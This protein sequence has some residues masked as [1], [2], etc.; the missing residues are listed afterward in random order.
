MTTTY[1]RH[2]KRHVWHWKHECRHLQVLTWT[3]TRRWLQKTTYRPKG[4]LCNE[5]KSKE[6]RAAR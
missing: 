4:D 5:C 6:R 3:W 1:Y 2:P